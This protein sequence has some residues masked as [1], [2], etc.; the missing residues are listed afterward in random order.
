[1][2]W[3]AAMAALSASKAPPAAPGVATAANSGPAF[4]S[5]GWTVN[6]GN[7]NKTGDQLPQSPLVYAALALGVVLLWKLAK[8]K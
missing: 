6:F 4:N 8:S 5:S 2:W 7:G 3:M 1:M